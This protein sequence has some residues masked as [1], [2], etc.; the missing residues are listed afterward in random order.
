MATSDGR[1]KE[2]GLRK[3]LGSSKNL[4][5]TQFLFEAQILTM[6]AMGFALIFVELL[7]PSVNNLLN[8]N[9]DLNFNLF[10][11]LILLGF[12]V[13]TGLISGFYP[14]T[15]LSSLRPIDLIKKTIRPLGSGNKNNSSSNAQKL[16]LRSGLV[17]FQFVLAIVLIAGIIVITKQVQFMKQKILVLIRKI[18][19]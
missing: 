2:I 1:I 15:F 4:L 18:Y 12:A 6:I 9:L 3:I 14:A 7:L 19:L 5:I 13:F 16:S 8:V 17:I 10:T 11:I